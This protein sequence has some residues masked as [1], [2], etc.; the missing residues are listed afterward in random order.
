ME[1]NV[2][3]ELASHQIPIDVIVD[4][5][6]DIPRFD[7]DYTRRLVKDIIARYFPTSFV[8]SNVVDAS[9][10]FC[11]GDDC[12]IYANADDLQK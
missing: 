11:L 9:P 6:S 7:E 4:F 2:I 10:Q 1:I 3:K 12:S 5:F 8:C